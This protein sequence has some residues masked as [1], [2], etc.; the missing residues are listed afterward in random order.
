MEDLLVDYHKKFGEYPPSLDFRS[1]TDEEM[2]ELIKEAIRTN[3]KI[4]HEIK[5]GEHF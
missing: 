5:D 3:V 4:E 1:V 2:T